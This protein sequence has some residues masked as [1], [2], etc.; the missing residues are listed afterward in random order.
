MKN[1][2]N[3]TAHCLIKISAPHPSFQRLRLAHETN[4]ESP[5]KREAVAVARLTAGEAKHCPSSLADII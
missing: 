1:N 4:D 2:P 3:K 5:S